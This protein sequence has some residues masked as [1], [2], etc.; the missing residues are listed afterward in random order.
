MFAIVDPVMGKTSE[1]TLIS[2]MRTVG[3]ESTED[4]FGIYL[5][6]LNVDMKKILSFAC[7]KRSSFMITERVSQRE[8][9][10]VPGDPSATGLVHFYQEGGRYVFLSQAQYEARK[11]ELPALCFATRIPIKHLIDLDRRL[12]GSPQVAQE[13]SRLS[14]LADLQEL[15][16]QMEFSEE[17]KEHSIPATSSGEPIHAEDPLYY[18]FNIINYAE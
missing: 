4:C 7:C 5:K 8:E 2:Y 3:A 17:E 16:T 12:G 10:M 14:R 18:S 6:R 13:L 15:A 11:N 1:Q 9:S